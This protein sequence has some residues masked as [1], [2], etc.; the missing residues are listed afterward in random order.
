M[1]SHAKDAAVGPEE[2][3]PDSSLGKLAATAIDNMVK[4]S[5][6]DDPTETMMMTPEVS[7]AREAANAAMPQE[8]RPNGREPLDDDDDAQPESQEKGDSTQEGPASASVA[9]LDQGTAAPAKLATVGK[10]APAITTSPSSPR[11]KVQQ[12][13]SLDR[14]AVDMSDLD[15]PNESPP[16]DGRNDQANGGQDADSSD[17]ESSYFAKHLPS[18]K[19]SRRYSFSSNASNASAPARTKH[20]DANRETD[21]SLS[22]SDESDDAHHSDS[23]LFPTAAAV[24]SPVIA[25]FQPYPHQI[26]RMRSVSSLV[27]TSSHNSSGTDR[28]VGDEL[29]NAANEQY[30]GRRSGV[31]SGRQSPILGEHP[32][33]RPRM[34]FS[35]PSSNLGDPSP[36]TILPGYSHQAGLPHPQPHLV[37]QEQWA[38][39]A[40][41]NAAVAQQQQRQQQMHPYGA[42][43]AVDPGIR[44][45][46]QSSSSAWSNDT[47][48]YSEDGGEISRNPFIGQA[49]NQPRIPQAMAHG[50]RT[51]A[52]VEE[53]L[54]GDGNAPDDGRSLVQDASKER[55]AQDVAV[56]NPGV[57]KEKTFEVYWQ[58]WIMLMYMS[59]LNL[60]VSR[61]CLDLVG[62]R[63]RLF[64]LSNKVALSNRITIAV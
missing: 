13:V 15:E 45:S 52:R 63:R 6:E 53:P 11:S 20:H 9:V 40:A 51:L 47:L 43:G 46:L 30:P 32:P 22:F 18:P 44:A 17:D 21:A 37:A 34:F 39:W 64:F 14:A 50:R 61:R 23:G 48:A 19:S 60:L 28:S 12:V 49:S 59:V 26:T 42:Y 25:H 57:Y 58:R 8:E 41:G 29:H 16:L 5:K 10:S 1:S 54:D 62:T 24:R 33:S 35:S 4:E 3:H 27:S 7:V 56:A 36:P 31:P 2:S 38:A 55:S